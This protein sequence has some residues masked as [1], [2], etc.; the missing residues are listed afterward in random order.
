MYDIQ[1]WILYDGYTK[2]LAVYL[3]NKSEDRPLQ[4]LVSSTIDLSDG[5]AD[6]EAYFSFSASR[7]EATELNCIKSWN[8]TVIE[9]PSLDPEDRTPL[10]IALVLVSLVFSFIVGIGS[11][12]FVKYRNS[13]AEATIISG[14][15]QDLP[16][17]PRE[18]KYKDLKKATNKFSAAYK[19]GS[20]GFGTVYKGIV[21]KENSVVAVKR[22]AKDSK[23]GKEEFISEISVINRL[24][25]RNLVPLL[26]WCHEKGKLIMV[27]EYMSNGS[28]DKHI[29][30]RNSCVGGFLDW[31]QRYK[32]VSGVAS[33]LLYLHEECE[34]QVI[35]WDVKASNIMLDSDY[36]ARLGDF[37]VAHLIEHDRRA[38]A[39]SSVA[40]TAG[41]I[42]PECL[43]SGQATAESDVF[44]FGAVALEV[45]CGRRPRSHGEE[46]ESDLVGEGLCPSPWSPL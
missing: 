26:G 40:R 13:Q 18:F 25:H 2:K 17:R 41:Y 5:I 35:H 15:L 43:L 27:Y 16:G 19:L 24:R 9:F 39:T 31:E 12:E 7:G 20:G 23:H 37:G 3:A 29:F 1:A 11:I 38:F 44:S 8:L 33:A 30:N 34:Q 42:A 32:I 22:I 10:L 36:N 14:A 46:E 21:P 6:A 45:A 28:L 4:S